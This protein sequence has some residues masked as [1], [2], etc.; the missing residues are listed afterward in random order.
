MLTKKFNNLVEFAK[1]KKNNF[2]LLFNNKYCSLG[3]VDQLVDRSLCMREV[4]GSKP[5]ISIA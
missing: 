5:G 4:P 2:Y 1:N 3:G